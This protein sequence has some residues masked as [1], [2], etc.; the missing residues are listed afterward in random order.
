MINR[1]RGIEW[2]RGSWWVVAITLSA[3]AFHLHSARTHHFERT[4]IEGVLSHLNERRGEAEAE[5]RDLEMRLQSQDDP[6]WIKMVLM[7]GLGVIP[8]GNIKVHFE[9]ASGAIK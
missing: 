2:F 6:E 3:Y 8:E 4:H 7:K 5:Q 9:E 1:D